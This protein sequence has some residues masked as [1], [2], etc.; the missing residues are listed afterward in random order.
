MLHAWEIWEILVL[1][2]ENEIETTQKIGVIL[3]WVL[4]K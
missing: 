2:P 3:E 1:K 4:Q